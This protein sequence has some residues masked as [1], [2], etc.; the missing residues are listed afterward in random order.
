MAGADIFLMPSLYEPCG[1]TQ[2]RA[3]RYGAPPIVR[4]RRRPGRYGGRWADRLLVRAV[5]PGSLRGGELPRARD[6]TR[7]PAKWQTIMRQGMARDFSWERSVATY[8][9][10]YRRALACRAG[11]RERA[12]RW[13]SFSPC[14]ATCPTC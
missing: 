10:V 9:D 11:A 12:D 4:R 1:L 7:D 6:C 8:L 5:H 3:Q 2:M 14:T 13:T